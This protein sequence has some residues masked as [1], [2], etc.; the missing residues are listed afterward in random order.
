MT[1]LK[2]ENQRLNDELTCAGEAHQSLSAENHR[3]RDALEAA[4]KAFQDGG[5]KAMAEKMRFGLTG[6]RP[7]PSGFK[8]PASRKVA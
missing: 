1:D 3:M 5:N 2:A 7:T 8:L 6:D 4:A